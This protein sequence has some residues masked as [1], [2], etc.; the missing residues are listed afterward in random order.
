MTF[1][2][3]C[4][5]RES[6]CSYPDC[7]NGRADGVADSV[8]TEVHGLRLEQVGDNWLLTGGIIPDECIQPGQKWVGSGGSSVTVQTV[9]P[10]PRYG[11]KVIYK[12]ADGSVN[13]KTPFSFQTRYSLVINTEVLSS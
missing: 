11:G 9:E 1:H 13:S 4:Q 2:C 6:E 10:H 3:R 12:Q 5:I 8:S 7:V